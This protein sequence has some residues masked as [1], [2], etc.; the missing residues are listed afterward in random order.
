MSNTYLAHIAPDGREQTVAEHLSGTARLCGRFAAAFGEEK[1][2]RLLGC[3]H[4]IG[5]C[6]ADFQK[7]LY[8]GPKVDHATAGALECAKIG[9][10]FPACC[11]IGHHS[12]LPDFGNPRNDTPGDP[13]CIGRLKKGQQGGIPAYQFAS[14]LPATDAPPQF[15]DTFTLSLWTRM[16]YSCLVDADFLDTEAFMAGN[17]ID[18]KPY[19]SLEVL[20]KRL[21]AYTS[22]WFPGET[23]L[24]RL[25]CDILTQ[26]IT[27]ASQPRGVYT[28]TVPTGGGKTVS[29]LAFALNHAAA[30]GLDR[31]I[32]VIP[33]TSIIEQNAQVFRNILGENNVVEHHSGISFDTEDE[34]NA[35]NQFQR[36]AAENWDA[37][38]IVTTAVQFFESLY[39]NHSSQCRKLHNI[40]N[41]VIIFDEAQMIPTC[42]LTPCVGAIANLVAHFRSSV[43]LCTA[44]QPVLGDL[45]QQF[46]PDLEIHEIS[47][48][49]QNSFQKFQRVTYQD[50]GTLSPEALSAQLSL[51]NQVL[52]IVNTRKEAQELYDLL[53]PDDSFHL[54]TLMYPAHRKAILDDIRQRL[55][56]GLPCRVVSTSLIEAGVDVDF[57]TV[58]RELAGLDSIAQAAGRCNRE[59]KRNV[60]D[61]I[62]T[63]FRSEVPPP[64]LQRQN[65]VAA[66]CAMQDGGDPSTPDT[67]QRY[68]SILRYNIG[69]NTD[70]SKAVVSLRNG[71]SGCYLPFK[72]VA[73]RFHLIDDASV[74]IY[75]PLGEGE[76]L[77]QRILEG[78]AN[79]NDYRKA[80]QYSV[81][82]YENHYRA[83]YSAGVVQPLTQ[84]S[85]VLTDTSLYNMKTG[86]SLAAESGKA[87]I[88]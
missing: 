40:A 59:G 50:G 62:V 2:G 85:A 32:Y 18:R 64:I 5:K 31:V 67:M 51:L 72:T 19:D 28:L 61:S 86:L 58:Y 23:D 73:D 44:T 29:S 46:S 14:P 20:L 55:A 27:A 12:G 38:V 60:K 71:I 54:S 25:R 79:R 15:R 41:S 53:P 88:L 34:T 39:A 3:A 80:G 22:P 17:A 63:F 78:F 37:P 35:H 10:N 68:F 74:T 42:H 48:N 36:L 49:V 84:D 30:N 82:V 24:N 81:S 7:R 6:S 26:C 43:V 33:Y 65:V 83:L 9:E 8:G 87:F 77:C 1:R 70:K 76:V 16:L 75:I 47:P 57:P 45:F 13:T 66:A 69:E 11:V 52:C 21:S 4:D 56:D